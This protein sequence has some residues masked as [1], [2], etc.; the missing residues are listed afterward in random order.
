VENTIRHAGLTLADATRLASTNPV[1][2][3]GLDGPKGRGSVRTGM[4]ADLTVFRFD[5][6]GTKLTVEQTI[7]GG[8][9]VYS[10]Y[11]QKTV[12]QR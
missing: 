2:L 10:E 8:T 4:A 9:T 7:V 12:R 5:A 3:L 6:A 1:R 11:E